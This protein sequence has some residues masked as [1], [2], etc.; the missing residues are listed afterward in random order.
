MLVFVEFER[1]SSFILLKLFFYLLFL[2]GGGHAGELR[3][4]RFKLKK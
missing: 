1:G 4:K 3:L 2:H